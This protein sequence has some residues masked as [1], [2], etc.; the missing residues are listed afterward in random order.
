MPVGLLHHRDPR[1]PLVREEKEPRKMARRHRRE[2]LGRVP[3]EHLPPDL[4][5]HPLRVRADARGLSREPHV[6]DG[7]AVGEECRMR[8]DRVLRDLLELSRAEIEASHTGVP[9]SDMKAR[10]LP[11]GENTGSLS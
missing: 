8:G 3:A 7:R 5:G 1:E 4:A 2:D 10:L 11:S 9:R 6:D